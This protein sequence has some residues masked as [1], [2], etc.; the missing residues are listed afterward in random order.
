MNALAP[1][2]SQVRSARFFDAIGYSTVWEDELVLDEGLTP[3]PGERALSI[4]S[5]G[6]STLQLLHHDV[7]EVVSLDFNAGQSALL[8]L[9][10][11][12][13]QHLDPDALWAFLG[14]GPSP[15]RAATYAALRPS[16][17][18]D[19]RA[20][21]DAHA[22]HV[23]AGVTLVG[24]QDR[25]IHLFARLLG[26]VQR[27]STIEAFFG[28]P[29]LEAQRR[30]LDARLGGVAWRALSRVLLSRFALD[31]AFHRAHFAHSTEVDPAGAFRRS[32]ERALRDVFIGDNFYLYYAAH[33][34]YPS[35]TRCPRWLADGAREQIRSRL[36]RVRI[37]TDEFE[38]FV[39][40]Q[41][42]AS[43]DL[44]NLSNIFDWVSDSAFQTLAAQLARIARPGAR[45]VYWTNVVNPV[46]RLDRAGV[47]TFVHDAPRSEALF[48]RSRVTGY[49]CCTCVRVVS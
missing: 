31:R 19:A 30:F 12:A 5:G 39:F 40:S 43:F 25:F 41:P 11:V 48:S 18:D 24:K 45:L 20:Y 14:L 26:W 13:L 28:Q 23:A 9:K 1:L 38:R 16:L 44:F 10:M 2:R 17:S 4:T 47:P 29:D 32:A 46:R 33:R 3:R 49:S 21:W 6:C 27:R 37:V 35:R 7:G 8:E 36:A 34:S 15:T 22:E 42:D